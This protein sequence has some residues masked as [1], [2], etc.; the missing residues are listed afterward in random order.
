[1]LAFNV[2]FD[3]VG[4][5]TGGDSDDDERSNGSGGGHRMIEVG[6]DGD[7][8]ED[9]SYA[10]AVTM[11]DSSGDDTRQTSKFDLSVD[12]STDTSQREDALDIQFECGIGHWHGLEDRFRQIIDHVIGHVHPP[13]PLLSSETQQ[14]L[15]W[16]Q[17]EE[18]PLTDMCLHELFEAKARTQPNAI[19]MIDKEG[20][21][22]MTYG[23]LDRRSHAVGCKLQSLGVR[24]NNFDGLLDC[25]WTRA[26]T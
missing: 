6:E 8:V 2:G 17:G 9:L 5:G 24:P 3:F 22:H 15:S 13:Q 1:M 23:E 11:D 4:E 16:G 25:W 14:V 26:L 18:R 21:I 12:W 20:S 7:D 10:A 19:A